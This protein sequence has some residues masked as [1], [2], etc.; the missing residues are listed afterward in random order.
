MK[1]SKNNLKVLFVIS[2]LL[3]VLILTF[4][5][6]K[7]HEREA[8]FPQQIDFVDK[9]NDPDS[10]WIFLLAGQSNMAGRGF[11]EPQDTIPNGRIITIDNSGEWIYAKE[12]LH[13]YEPSR[14]GLDCGMAFAR[15]LLDSIPI[16]TSVAII[17]C[18]IGGSAIEEWLRNETVRGVSLLTNFTKKVV[19]VKKYGEIKGI[20]W[21]QGESDAK[22]ELIPKY[23]TNLDS[24]VSVF[25]N[26]IQN[27]SLP[28]LIG[29]LG[30]YAE[31]IER[32]QRWDSINRSIYNFAM[33]NRNIAVV[34]TKDLKHKGDKVHFDSESQRKL[35][36][37]FA[38]KY[39]EMSMPDHKN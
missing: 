38:K 30:S 3:C 17:P 4:D 5:I 20:L 33:N 21:H 32:H 2:I 39:L 11:V 26:I 23:S 16:N 25:R 9:L 27:D 18:A 34:N 22:S 13:L 8:N 10:L 15:T 24:L 31:P 28:I 6:P 35:G 12:P 36:A 7:Q 19:Q 37:R 1:I 29:E 14:T